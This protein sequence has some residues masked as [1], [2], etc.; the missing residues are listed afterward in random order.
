[1]LMGQYWVSSSVPVDGGEPDR[2]LSHRDNRW[3]AAVTHLGSLLQSP[4]AK[5]DKF[6]NMKVI[7]ELKSETNVAPRAMEQMT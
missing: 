2:L 6:G 4:D 7:S 1:M 5:A 3:C